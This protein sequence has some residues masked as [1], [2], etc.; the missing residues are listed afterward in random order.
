MEFESKFFKNKKKNANYEI[1]GTI[2]RIKFELR[3]IGKVKNSAY[4]EN[5][6]FYYLYCKYYS[7]DH[8]VR[9]ITA[10]FDR[11]KCKF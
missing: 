1:V 3:S 9:N 7:S 8:F 4:F 11:E 5:N 2:S 6:P 10:L